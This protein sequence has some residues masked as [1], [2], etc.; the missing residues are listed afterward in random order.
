MSEIKGVFN[1]HIHEGHVSLY[2]Y[3]LGC[4]EEHVIT[5]AWGWNGSYDKPTFTSSH[6]TWSGHYDPSGRGGC[7]CEFNKN[8]IAKGEE[9]SKFTCKR[10]HSMIKDG[11][12][13]YLGD[14]THDMAG[15]TVDIPPYREE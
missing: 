1:E 10:C 6:I 5:P 8:L 13:E 11:K 3:C 12:Q 4:K 14:C 7:W 15:Q 9:P 2:F